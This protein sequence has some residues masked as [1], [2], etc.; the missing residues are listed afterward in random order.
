MRNE[1]ILSV[2]HFMFAYACFTYSG[3][4]AIFPLLMGVYYLIDASIKDYEDDRK[5]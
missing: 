2:A 3:L 4:L 1:F 5:R